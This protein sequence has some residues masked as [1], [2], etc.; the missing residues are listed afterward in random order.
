MFKHLRDACINNVRWRGDQVPNQNRRRSR[1]AGP[2]HIVTFVEAW[3]A[4]EVRIPQKKFVS[5]D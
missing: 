3:Q 2:A 5:S 1:E 4:Q